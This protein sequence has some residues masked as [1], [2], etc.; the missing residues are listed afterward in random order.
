MKCLETRMRPNGLR[1]RR[2]LMDDGRKLVTY[3][4]PA[5]V[6]KSVGLGK[7][8]HYMSAWQRG[9]AKRAESRQRRLTIESMLREKIKP[10]AIAFEVGVTETRVRQ[11]RQEMGL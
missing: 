9:E 11:I 10:L 1:M 3:E 8:E 6:I 2:Y 4:M 5:T 7:I